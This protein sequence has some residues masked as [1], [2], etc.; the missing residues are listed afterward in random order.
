[1]GTNKLLG[2]CLF[3]I[4]VLVCFVVYVGSEKG[5]KGHNKGCIHEQVTSGGKTELN[6]TGDP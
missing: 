4:F 5:K 2:V 6:P 1:M 3:F